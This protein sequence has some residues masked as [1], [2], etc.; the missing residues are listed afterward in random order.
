MRRY[1]FYVK[2]H[3]RD[4][5]QI[6]TFWDPLSYCRKII[7]PKVSVQRLWTQ[8]LSMKLS[9]WIEICTPF[10]GPK[11]KNEFVNQTFFTNGSG[12]IH[13]IGFVKIFW[14]LFFHRSYIF[15]LLINNVIKNKNVWFLKKLY[16]IGIKISMQNFSFQEDKQIL[17]RAF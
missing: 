9:D 5:H 16:E 8:Q 11:R 14:W 3:S 15:C 17:F 4:F 10:E 6:F 12:F 7:F 1:W 2:N 13:K